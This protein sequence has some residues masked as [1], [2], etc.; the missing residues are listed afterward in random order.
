MSKEE[1]ANLLNTCYGRDGELLIHR[2]VRNTSLARR[3]LPLL[4]ALG[5]STHTQTN[6]HSKQPGST[7]WHLAARDS[8]LMPLS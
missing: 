6:R 1:T 4:T 7:V 5:A 3:T 8:T 2:L